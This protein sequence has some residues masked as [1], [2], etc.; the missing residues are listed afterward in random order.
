VF[1]PPPAGFVEVKISGPMSRAEGTVATHSDSDGHEIPENRKKMKSPSRLKLQAP[2]GP[3]GS[4][5]AKTV[6]ERSMAAHSDGDAHDTPLIAGSTKLGGE[7]CGGAGRFVFVQAPPPPAGL[8]LVTTFP[9]ESPATQN[10]AV[11]QEIPPSPEGSIFTGGAKLSGPAASAGEAVNPATPI[12]KNAAGPA[13]RQRRA[14]D[15]RHELR[16]NPTPLS[17]ALSRSRATVHPPRAGCK[18][19]PLSLR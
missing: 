9:P 12:A 19:A 16:F 15:F 8:V 14:K 17:Q 4:A 5:E 13:R 11:G 7:D 18:L 1:H 2:A 10:D 3:V 6:P